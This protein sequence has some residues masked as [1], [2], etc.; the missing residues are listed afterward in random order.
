MAEHW[1]AVEDLFAQLAYFAKNLDPNGIELYD[2]VSGL[3]FKS[4]DTSS[5]LEKLDRV[6]PH[7]GSSRSDPSQ[8][9]DKLLRD[10]AERLD[11]C[12]AKSKMSRWPIRSRS[13]VDPVTIYILTDGVW[14]PKCD[15]AGPIK[16]LMTKMEQYDL[17]K[18]QVGIQFIQFGDDFE[19]SQKLA[20]LDSKKKS[21][22]KMQVNHVLGYQAET[23]LTLGQ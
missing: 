19:G 5:L 17:P 13:R 1:S 3:E 18:G 2:T 22:F 23:L 9:I 12:Y 15:V 21:G 6:K 14:Q 8:R 11:D 20:K 10:Y 16:S 7:S 4:P